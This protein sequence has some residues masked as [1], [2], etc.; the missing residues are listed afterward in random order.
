MNK[1]NSTILIV[2][3]A[4]ENIT[5]LGEVLQGYKKLVALNGEKALQII[6]T[7][8]PDLILLDIVMPGMD[9]FEVCR[10]LKEDPETKDIPVIFITG[11]TDISDETRG[12]DLGAVDFIPKPISAPVVLARVNNHLELSINR[13][14]LAE[15]NKKLE[16]HNK[17]ITDS[18]N[19]AKRIQQAILPAKTIFEKLFA[20]SFLIFRPKDIVSGDFY[21]AGEVHGEKIVVVVD[22][23]GH[24]VPGAFMSMIGNTLL[25]DIV[26]V[27]GITSPG[28]ILHALDEGIIHE[29]NKDTHAE[30]FDGMDAAVCK[31]AA[32]KNEVIFAGAYRPMYVVEGEEL[33]EFKGDKKSLGD[34]RKSLTF[35]EH[36]VPY[37][38]NTCFYVFTDGITDQ[39]NSENIK[40]GSG[41]LKRVLVQL[42]HE[43]LISQKEK[44]IE[45][46]MNHMGEESQR[47]DITFVGLR[48]GSYNQSGKKSRIRLEHDTM[49]NLLL[50]DYQGI[51]DHEL[52][53]EFTDILEAEVSE[54]LPLPLYKILLFSTNE[55]I[56]NIGFYSA[57]RLDERRNSGIGSFSVE[58]SNSAFLITTRNKIDISKYMMI[59][60]KIDE[61]NNLSAEE[62][63]AVYKQKVRS[64]S[65]AE[66][67]GGGIGII[68]VLRKTKS[69]ITADLQADTST[70][71]LQLQI[72]RG[73]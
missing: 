41:N 3:D 6:Q 29:L 58:F 51:C 73:E 22:C 55:M 48:P 69:K 21:W 65:D 35:T 50:I 27:K 68:E 57:E 26:L 17:F 36:R 5:I 33:T 1:S 49:G 38:G 12:L 30:T 25:N 19:Y 47:D 2:D 56:Q 43:P 8:K 67:K 7:K 42:Q 70:M 54:K 46:L 32:G 23:T 62:L 52:I 34:V 60:T 72:K 63:K 66:S 64:A 10:R 71:I 18:I 37:T 15:Q 11:Q 14:Q 40:Y 24:G 9:G 61:F 4:P 20:E 59:K 44:I 31:F 45:I 53:E 13:R 16:Q 28:K 39:N